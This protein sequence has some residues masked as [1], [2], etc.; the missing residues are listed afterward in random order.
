MGLFSRKPKIAVCDMCGKADIEGC[1]STHKHV[2]RISG[3]Q[4]AWLP[5]NLRAQA[6]GEYTW[7]CVRCDS[8]PAMKWPGDGGAEAGMM[9]H[10]GSKHSVGLM[11]GA[12]SANFTMIPLR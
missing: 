6:Q 12:G 11:R 9:I 8:Y 1:G 7:L 10:L 5:A 3:D 2:E 4:P